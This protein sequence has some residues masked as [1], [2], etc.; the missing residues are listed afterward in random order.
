MT[1][2]TLSLVAAS[3]LLTQATFADTTL[4]DI[5][6]ISA[7]KTTQKLKNITSN[8]E[9]ITSQD[10]EE[11]GYTTVIQA[12]KS[13]SGFTFTQNGG[14]GTSS[15]V[16]LRGMNAKSVLVLIDGVRYN[17][18]TSTS[19]ATFAHLMVEDIA[20]IEVVKGS[21]SGIW[22]ADAAAGVINIITKKAKSGIHGSAHM[23]A[24][25]F[26]TKKYGVTLSS[27]TKNYSLKVSH[28]V[29]DTDSF[30]AQSP[31]GEDIDDFEDDGYKNRTTN[32]QM[33]LNLNENNKIDMT[34]TFIDAKGEY[35]TYHNPNGIANSTTKDSFASINFNHVDNFNELNIYI[36][37]SKF[38]R[39]FIDA[40]TTSPFVG[41]VD[42]YGINSKIPYGM[43]DFIIV[44]ADY[45]KFEHKKDIYKKFNNKGIFVTNSN[46]FKGKIGGTTIV[47]ESLRYDA[48][49]TFDNEFTG[50][51]GL[52][53]IHENIEG[54]ITSLNYGTS[55]IVPTLYQLYA[56]GSTF[57]GVYYP[58]GN[59]D[60]NPE[61]T[62]SF[63]VTVAY[64]DFSIT[65]F[66]NRINNLIEYTNG[67]NNV[68]GTSQ[69][70]GVEISYEREIFENLL[71]TTNYTHLFGFEN[72]DEKTLARRAKDTFNLAVDY[73]GI[74]KLHIGADMQYVGERYDKA[75]KQ[76][77]QTGKY[78]VFNMSVDYQINDRVK[79]YG[80]IEN[81]AD[82]TYQTVDGYATSPRAFYAGVR[83]KF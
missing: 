77:E 72:H 20:Q 15:S 1:T 19:G 38:D 58:I 60:L 17:D 47:T 52:K 68:E 76:G 41:Q 82:K 40:Y 31:K 33:G 61:I 13:L 54:L 37:R 27:K 25:S 12:L 11:R 65:Y 53:H 57:G 14:L 43:E 46:T 44:G 32:V 26:N 2:K 9:V 49:S 50:K 28:N 4:E 83:A 62:K 36:K 74:E 73:Y 10:I 59:K 30:T 24:G 5:T 18:I 78:S 35:D 55:Y 39:K 80:K 42:E 67:Y 75:D 56:P 29:V 70:D 8:V 23:E 34:Y 71:L 81:I 21:Q 3:L 22:G 63:D 16:K 51:I 48:Y 45:K 64:K 7:T 66:N 79:I 69:I 6:V